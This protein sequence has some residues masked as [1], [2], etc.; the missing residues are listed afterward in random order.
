MCKQ[1]ARHRFKHSVNAYIIWRHLAWA[2]VAARF[3][4]QVLAMSA[5]DAGLMHLN[6]ASA[7]SLPRVTTRGQNRRTAGPKPRLV[8]V[9]LRHPLR[10]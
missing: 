8:S 3:L 7:S 5:V 6:Y 10:E 9:T 2:I 4:G 1:R